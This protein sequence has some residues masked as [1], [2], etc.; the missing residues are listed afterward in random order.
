MSA[1]GLQPY[2]LAP[3]AGEALWVLGGRYTWKAKGQQTGGAYSLCEVAG[4][5][6][7]AIPVHFH[8]LEH[9]GF[10]VASGV[11]TLV[12]GEERTTVSAGGFGFA[13]AEVPH[14][15]R[16]EAPDTRLLLLIT[17]GAHGHEGM[18]AE[19]GRPAEGHAAPPQSEEAPDMDLLVGIAARHGTRIV[20][21]PPGPEVS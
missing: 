19:L 9:E 14:S 8:Q 7:F 21:P 15:F 2:A 11:V 16:L 10:Y 1:P 3:E 5:Q 18:F 17:P 12:L 4:P 6:G 20:G 13:P